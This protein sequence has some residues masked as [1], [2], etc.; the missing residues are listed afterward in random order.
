VLGLWVVLIVMFL[1]IWQFLSP[2]KG[3][4]T[5]A[6]P[7][8]VPPDAIAITP[9]TLILTA[10]ALGVPLV[11]FLRIYRSVAHA[12]R[13]AQAMRRA[14]RLL[15]EG[16][17]PGAQTVMDQVVRTAPD[18]VAASALLQ[19]ALVAERRCD[20]KAALAHC[21]AGLER[22]SRFAQVRAANSDILVPELIAQRAFVLAALDR[23]QQAMAELATLA[24]EH[25][26]FAFTSRSVL[27]VR[28]VR[29]LRRMDLTEAVGLARERTPEL[30]L[31]RR[32]EML[33]DLVIALSGG[34]VLEGEIERLGV[35]L[36][37]D[38][39]LAAWVDFMA[40]GARAELAAASRARVAT[41]GVEA[42][43]PAADTKVEPVAD[44]D[45]ALVTSR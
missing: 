23:D 4:P 32:D 11:L 25:P 5:E 26:T 43:S 40:P 21:D 30:P 41:P 7:P 27:R 8:E 39:E 13:G 42:P 6:P 37:E 35:E 36:A 12:R 34:R 18:S 17:T 31:S 19:L 33:A 9:L 1:A 14:M 10:L 44:A 2:S 20:L 16:D 24:R 22:I 29:A 38:A 15:G 45:A 28:L 3:T